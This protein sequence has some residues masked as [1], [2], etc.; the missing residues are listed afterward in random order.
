MIPLYAAQLCTALD[1]RPS[2]PL[3]TAC[4]KA[5]S[6]RFCQKLSLGTEYKAQKKENADSMHAWQWGETLPSFVFPDIILA[7]E[8]Q[9]EALTWA[10]KPV[11]T[12]RCSMQTLMHREGYSCIWSEFSLLLTSQGMKMQLHVKAK[13]TGRQYHCLLQLQ[14]MPG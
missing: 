5:T 1:R 4:R 13:Q 6:A 3:P 12:V 8:L 9:L 2:A 14:I 11:W 10:A 7:E